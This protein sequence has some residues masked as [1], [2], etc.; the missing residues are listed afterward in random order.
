MKPVFNTVLLVSL[1]IMSSSWGSPRERGTP[2]GGNPKPRQE[3]YPAPIVGG[4]AGL[5]HH[6]GQLV[7]GKVVPHGARNHTIWLSRRTWVA[8]TGNTPGM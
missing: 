1:V 7:R 6:M 3:D 8:A 5:A 4:A 2:Q